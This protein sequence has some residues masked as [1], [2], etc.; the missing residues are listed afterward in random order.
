MS[1][2]NLYPAWPYLACH[3]TQKVYFVAGL[4]SAQAAIQ[5]M[6]KSLVKKL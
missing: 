2:G 1:K 4:H 5:L 3:C 6:S